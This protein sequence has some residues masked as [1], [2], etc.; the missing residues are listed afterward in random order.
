MSGIPTYSSLSPLF[1]TE[2]Q[3]QSY[4]PPPT[5]IV[6]QGS[7]LTPSEMASHQISNRPAL[8][9]KFNSSA[10]AH[11]RSD[12]EPM[13]ASSG[14]Q[15]TA[16]QAAGSQRSQPGDLHR[17]EDGS[18]GSRLFIPPLDLFMPARNEPNQLQQQPLATNNRFPDEE[19]GHMYSNRPSGSEVNQSIAAGSQARVDYHQMGVYAEPAPHQYYQQPYRPSG[20]PPPGKHKSLAKP[21]HANSLAKRRGPMVRKPPCAMICNSM[22]VQVVFSKISGEDANTLLFCL[23]ESRRGE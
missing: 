2:E 8:Q 3:S 19:A 16:Q 7:M 12:S 13:Y 4:V 17:F 5:R 1:S 10:P 9:S 23:Y 15:H 11:F 20:K 6:A 21:E 18:Q 22:E 14:S